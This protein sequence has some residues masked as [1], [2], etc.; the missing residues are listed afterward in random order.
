M[1]GMNIMLKVIQNDEKFSTSTTIDDDG[2][3]AIATFTV[4][5]EKKSPRNVVAGAVFDFTDVSRVDLVKLAMKSIIITEQSRY[6]MMDD[7]VKRGKPGTW[8]RKHNVKTEFVNVAKAR[9]T[10]SEKIVGIAAS[11]GNE[12]LK[13]LMDQM[14]ALMEKDGTEDGGPD[15][16]GANE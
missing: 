9:K 14:N 10:T 11:M 13:T 5:S 3:E 16:D 8:E 12:E 1:N 2:N 6:R 4:R 7:T 15:Y